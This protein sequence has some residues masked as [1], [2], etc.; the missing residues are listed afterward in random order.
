MKLTVL[1][2]GVLPLAIV[3]CV[4]S[5]HSPDTVYYTP[6]SATVTTLP[7]TSDS[8]A[9]RV[10]PGSPNEPPVT[11]PPGDVLGSDMAVADEIRDMLKDDPTLAAASDQVLIQVN[12]GVVSLRGTVPTEHDLDEIVGRI[13]RIPG[14]RQV[15]N[16]LGIDLR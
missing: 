2:L 6:P 11:Q 13:S 14:V 7:P 16:H 10:Y 4:S 5:H 12:G 9:V 15:R 3:A 1:T 8:P